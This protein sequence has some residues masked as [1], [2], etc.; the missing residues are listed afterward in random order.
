MAFKQLRYR[1]TA[2]WWGLAALSMFASLSTAP[3]AASGSELKVGKAFKECDVCPEMIV[4]PS[5]MFQMGSNSGDSHEKPVHKVSIRTFAVGKHE[6]T[7]GQYLACARSK[8]CRE[9][10]WREAGSKYNAVTG[11]DREYTKLGAALTDKNHPIIGVSLLDAKSYAGWLSKRTG[12]RYR[13]L[14]EAEWEYAAR[15][16][17]TSDDVHGKGSANCD[18]CGSR[19]DNKQTAPVGSF[20]A[21]GFGLHD[22]LGN[23]WE[24]TLDCWNKSYAGNPPTN[25]GVWDKGDCFTGVLRGGS[26]VSDPAQVRA[27][28]RGWIK[29]T[30]RLDATGFRVARNVLR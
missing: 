26:W 15:G 3:F 16:G 14:S 5:G 6:V 8:A 2:M 18:G 25:G 22:M 17:A 12:K 29:P 10:E 13:L 9:P 4:L 24:W 1:L 21:N 23:V 20:R 28:A 19:W 7:V 30:A 27:A 11:S